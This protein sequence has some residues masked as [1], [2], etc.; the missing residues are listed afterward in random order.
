MMDKLEKVMMP[1]ASAIGRNKF[2]I[3][4]R[5]GFLVSTPLLIA[6]SIFLLLANFPITAWVE[7]VEGFMIGNLSLASL[8]SK[9]SDATFSLMAIFATLGIGY[10]MAREEG[11]TPI[12]GAAVALMS[13]FILMPFSF[14]ANI[15]TLMADGAAVEIPEGAT[16]AVSGLQFGWLGSKGLFVGI[17]V[18]IASVLLYAWVERKGWVIKMPA[19]VPPTV[20]ASF[21]A[22]I[23][24]TIVMTTFFLINL[25]FVACGT[26]AFDFIFKFLQTPLL[27]LGD[28][29]GAMIVA[30]IFLHLFWFFGINGGSVVGAVFNPI[31][32]TLALENLDLYR[33]VGAA[34]YTVANGAHIISQQFQDLFATFGGC[35]STLSLLIAMLFFCKSKRVLEL[36][37]LSLVAGIFN[38]NEPIVF[39]L[40]IV[41]NPVIAIPFILVP[42]MNIILTYF[43]MNMGLFPPCN[44]INIPWTMPVIISG[45]LAT[46][47][48]GALFQAFLLVLGVFVYLPF[49]KVLDRQYLEEERS[50]QESGEEEIDL[51]DLDLADL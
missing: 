32:Q 38:I 22:L 10:S 15:K 21:S 6:G 11:T 23:P 14:T 45:F 36:G 46:N 34:G 50:A 41:L 49:I 3:A 37:K 40:P 51:D 26:T 47:W 2:L 9:C 17:I 7:F 24:A 19:G 44:G 27:G 28:T 8:L 16:S 12:F 25:I 39:G 20:V 31:L 4:I 35:G 48:V 13:W 29:L 1:L 42:M 43:A 18:A 33:E 30:Y 5:D